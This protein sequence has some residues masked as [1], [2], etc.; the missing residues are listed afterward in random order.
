LEVIGREGDLTQSTKA[1]EA[2]KQELKRLESE[3]G[4]LLVEFAV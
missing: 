2:L 4:E 3:L 1:L